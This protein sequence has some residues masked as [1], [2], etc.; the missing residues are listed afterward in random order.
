[1]AV[2][3]YNQDEA[4][5]DSVSHIDKDGH[6][7]FF[8]PKKPTGKLY[9]WRTWVSFAFLVVFFALPFVKV[10]GEP[11]FLFNIIDRK[12]ILFGV[13]FWPQDFFLFVLGMIIFI[14]FIALFTVVFGR[15][16]CGWVCPQTIFMEMVFRKIEYW[17]EGDSAQQ[18]ALRKAPWNGEKMRKRLLKIASFY[19]LSFLFANFF[20]AY[21]IGIDQVLKIAT[22]PLT[23]HLGGFAAIVIFSGIFFFIYYWFREQA[24]L[25]VCPYGRMQGVLLDKNSIVVAYD[26]KRG[27]PRHK[28]TKE[29]ASQYG[30]CIDCNECVRVCPTGIDIRHG[31]QLECT[32]CTACIDACDGIMEKIDRPKGLVR[33][34]SEMSIAEGKKLGITPRIIAY[35]IVLVALISLESFL[36]ATRSDLDTTIIRARGILY[37]TEPDGRI[38]NLYN[39]KIINKTNEDLDLDFLVEEAGAEIRIV[40]ETLKVKAGG[41]VDGQFFLIRPAQNIHHQKDKIE[42][43]VW[44]HGQRMQELKTTFLGPHATSN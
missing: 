8:H 25:V 24:C 15:I 6:R 30:D 29:N 19:A 26:Y 41:Y 23:M 42:V 28:F 43:E 2:E 14:V 16:F 32:N 44:A 27:E 3:E 33:Y 21:I 9:R 1:M 13:Q 22:E 11:L 31:T 18:R 20:L 40:G 37:N 38:S 17:I 34:A 39:V 7:V 35:S 36:L 5:R 10:H 12:F 4:F